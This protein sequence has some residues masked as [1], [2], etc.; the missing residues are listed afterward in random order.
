MRLFLASY[1]QVP[2]YDALHAALAPAFEARWVPPR[3]LHLTW[4]FLGERPDPA[5][6]I[7]RLGPLRMLPRLP[8]TLRGVGTFGP[9]ERPRVLHLA[10]PS[11]VPAILH[12]KIAALLEEPPH[13]P[14]TPHVTLARIDAVRDPAWPERLAPFRE[15]ELG[16]VE[17]AIYL[18]E[19]RLTPQ[20]PIYLPLEE[21]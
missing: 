6:V 18:I 11:A 20:G 2:E 19:S 14:F 21:F 5:P 10:A 8:L 1:A 7:D 13:E 3:N 9:T 12:E 16:T 17:P 15:R 4:L